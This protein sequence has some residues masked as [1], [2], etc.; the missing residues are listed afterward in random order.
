MAGSQELLCPFPAPECQRGFA[1]SLAGDG[2]RGSEPP[3]SPFADKPS[4]LAEAY[5]L[6][7]TYVRKR[8]RQGRRKRQ[9]QGSRI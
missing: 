8:G 1:F 5:Q 4:E 9:A 7:N 2:K 3:D 6:H